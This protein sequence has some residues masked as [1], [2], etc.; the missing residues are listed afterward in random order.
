M[1]D[2]PPL[3]NFFVVGTGKAGTTSLH[4]YLGQ[5]PQVFMSPVKEPAY[6]ASEVRAANLTPAFQRHLAIQTKSLPDRL[7]DGRPVK[8]LGWLASEWEDYERLF[9]GVRGESAIGDAS[10]IYLWSETAAKNIQARVPDARI[11]MILRDPAER[12]FSHYLHQLAVGFTRATFREHIEACAR[13]EDRTISTL[14]PFLEIGL[15]YQQVKR[16]LDRFPQSHIRIYWYEEDWRQPARM[17]ADL[18]AFLNVDADFQV[19]TSRKS[20]ERRA[21]RMATLSYALKKYQVWYPLRSLVPKGL[22]PSLSRLAF[23]RGK[24]LTMQPADRQY[25]IDYYREDIG[26]LATLL[27]RDLSAWL[28]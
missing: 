7:Q 17:L 2:R 26:R 11:V 16:F 15:Y 5:H 28:Q 23:R 14:Y 1:T 13:N 24:S 21:P 18:F 22:R 8:P 19:D 20:L 3:P 25:L 9:Q 6:F 4:D 12:A 27:D 10:P